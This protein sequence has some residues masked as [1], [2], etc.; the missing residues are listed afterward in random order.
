[1]NYVDLKKLFGGKRP[2]L[3]VFYNLMNGL[4]LDEKDERIRQVFRIALHEWKEVNDTYRLFMKNLITANRQLFICFYCSETVMGALLHPCGCVETLVLF[5]VL[6][7]TYEIKVK[8]SVRHLLFCMLLVFD[9]PLSLR[10]LSNYVSRLRLSPGE[11]L[12]I[13]ARAKIEDE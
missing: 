3:P 11:L 12:D 8:T 1:M 9:I 4:T 5:F 13:Y 6:W 7:H 10:S 2:T